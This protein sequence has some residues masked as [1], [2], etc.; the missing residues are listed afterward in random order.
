MQ[1]KF[2]LLN[3]TV[4]IVRNCYLKR[5]PFKKLFPLLFII[6]SVASTIKQ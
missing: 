6:K 1:N 5:K 2:M 4:P 3:I